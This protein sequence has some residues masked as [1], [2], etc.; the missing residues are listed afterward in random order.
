MSATA[1]IHRPGPRLNEGTVSHIDGD[2]VDV[3]RAVSTEWKAWDEALRGSG[4]RLVEVAPGTSTRAALLVEDTM[5]V[6][7]APRS[8]LATGRAVPPP[9]QHH[10][11]IRLPVW[12]RHHHIT[13]PCTLDGGDILEVGDV[14]FMSHEAARD[15]EGI[16]S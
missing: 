9:G 8:H 14:V 7:T 4:T 15:G 1:L 10:A 11:E 13:A 16:D 5:V 12:L 3:A 2:P 6:L